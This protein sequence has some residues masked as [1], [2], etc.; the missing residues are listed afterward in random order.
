MWASGCITGKQKVEWKKSLFA[1][2]SQL[3]KIPDK[4]KGF[5]CQKKRKPA[6]GQEGKKKKEGG[7]EEEGKEERRR[8]E[9]EISKQGNLTKCNTN[10][11][12][13]MSEGEMNCTL[14][15]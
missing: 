11:C 2:L 4:G 13:Q 12:V 7:G 1:Y 9:G 6:R 14:C 15:A 5:I 8:L 3:L 10:S